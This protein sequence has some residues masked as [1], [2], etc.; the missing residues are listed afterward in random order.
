MKR[1]CICGK[2]FEGWGNNP[3]PVKSSGECCDTCNY[4]VVLPARIRGLEKSISKK[5]SIKDAAINVEAILTELVE[6]EE[7]AIK[8]YDNAIRM[9]NQ[10][11]VLNDRVLIRLEEIKNDE[12]EHKQELNQLLDLIKN[13]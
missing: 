13:K 10:D 5:D 3:W 1:C 9:L 4:E 2:E 12:L 11:S 6:S 7:D 8:L